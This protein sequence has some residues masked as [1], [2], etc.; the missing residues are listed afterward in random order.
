MPGL[1]NQYSLIEQSL[2]I[3]VTVILESIINLGQSGFFELD[4]ATCMIWISGLIQL[5]CNADDIMWI[6]LLQSMQQL[7]TSMSIRF[8]IICLFAYTMYTS[9][10]KI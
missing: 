6:R 10:I 4:P 8:K 7:A 1:I 2:V 3:F 5:G 9:I